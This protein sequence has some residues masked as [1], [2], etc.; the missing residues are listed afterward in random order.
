MTQAVIPPVSIAELNTLKGSDITTTIQEQIDSISSSITTLSGTLSYINN[1]N[2]SATD[3][4]SS[5]SYVDISGM[6]NHSFTLNDACD[7]FITF[8]PFVILGSGATVV[9]QIQ[10]VIDSAGTPQLIELNP[11]SAGVNAFGHAARTITYSLDAGAH[12]IKPQWKKTG[13]D[14]SLLCDVSLPWGCTIVA[15]RQ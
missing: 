1:F 6:S 7:L 14:G 15:F 5:A 12:T 8:E 10:L 4:S 13:G 2:F 3:S 9:F 11:D